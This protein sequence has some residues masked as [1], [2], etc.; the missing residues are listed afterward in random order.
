M[1]GDDDESSS[2]R[3]HIACSTFPRIRRVLPSGDYR[4]PTRTINKRRVEQPTHI[5]PI[6]PQPEH[7]AALAAR[8]V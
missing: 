8:P 6:P 3:S 2:G 1:Y 5:T 4:P 7:S